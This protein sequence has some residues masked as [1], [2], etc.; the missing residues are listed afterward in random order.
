MNHDFKV[1]QD[2]TQTCT[3]NLDVPDEFKPGTDIFDEYVEQHIYG[4][5]DSARWKESVLRSHWGLVEPESPV[6]QILQQVAA[7]HGYTIL[8]MS[9]GEFAPRDLEGFPLIKE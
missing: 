2:I 1:T 6:I 7:D 3:V 5:A 8:K 4:V 9:L